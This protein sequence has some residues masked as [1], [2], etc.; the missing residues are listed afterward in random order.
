MKFMIEA[1]PKEVAEMLQAIASSQE[2]IIQQTIIL[3]SL[4]YF[5]LT[6][7]V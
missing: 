4:I 3:F 7:D 1:T 2:Q 6:K 5:A